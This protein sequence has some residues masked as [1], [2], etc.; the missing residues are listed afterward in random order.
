MQWAN[1]FWARIYLCWWGGARVRQNGPQRCRSLHAAKTLEA[2]ADLALLLGTNLT[3]YCYPLKPSP[4]E[5]G[6]WEPKLTIR[7]PA[8]GTMWTLTLILT[9]SFV[10]HSLTSSST[11]QC[12]YLDR[13]LTWMKSS[14]QTGRENLLLRFLARVKL[15]GIYHYFIRKGQFWTN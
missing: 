15:R 7:P 10:D 12:D 6:W 13:E 4:A 1:Q 5:R 8:S 2:C 11:P 3:P 14:P 9:A